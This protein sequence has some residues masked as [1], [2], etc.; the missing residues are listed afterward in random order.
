[1]RKFLGLMICIFLASTLVTYLG[2]KKKEEA[3]PAPTE[4]AAP[5]PPEV[6]APVPEEAPTV[7]EAP[8]A[9]PTVEEAPPVEEAP[10]EEPAKGQKEEGLLMEGC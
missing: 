3:P 5:A 7:E 9:A 4:E 10:T 6:K 2:C 8:P 1:M